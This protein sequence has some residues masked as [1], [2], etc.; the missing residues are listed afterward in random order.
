MSTHNIW[1]WWTNKKNSR[2]IT[3]NS[4]WQFF[5]ITYYRIK[6]TNVSTLVQHYQAKKA[7][8]LSVFQSFWPYEPQRQETY[9]RTCAPS[10]ES[11]Q[12]ARMRRL[13]S[14]LF[15]RILDS[16]WSKVSSCG[17]RRLWPDCAQADLNLRC[18]HTSEVRFLAFR[19]LILNSTL[20]SGL[21]SHA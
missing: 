2:T 18:A 4:T 6:N 10:E 21:F 12:P 8:A 3:K 19:P 5:C 20:W 17:Q 14:I 16:Q 13:I 9:L 11:D 15:W 7:I 1:F